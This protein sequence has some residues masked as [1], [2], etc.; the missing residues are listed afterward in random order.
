V[1]SKTRFSL[2]VPNEI[3]RIIR[4]IARAIPIRIPVRLN[5]MRIVGKPV[6]HAVGQRGI[7]DLF[8]PARDRQFGSQDRGAHV[9]IARW[10]GT[11]S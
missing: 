5:M 1:A 11:G 2:N 7:P 4:A 10:T 8:V 9:A 3:R 6:E